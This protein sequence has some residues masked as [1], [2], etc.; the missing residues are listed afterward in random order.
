[1]NLL[2]RLKLCEKEATP[3]PWSFSTCYGFAFIEKADGNEKIDIASAV[4]YLRPD[5]ANMIVEAR[6]ALPKLLRIVKAAKATL[7]SPHGLACAC[8][9]EVAWVCGPCELDQALKELEQ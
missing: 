7:S 6:N 8:D 3:C 4:Q 1:M 2:E 9:I 5:N